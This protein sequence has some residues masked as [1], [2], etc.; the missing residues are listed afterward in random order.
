M[1][2]PRSMANPQTDF[3]L[4][5]IDDAVG[6]HKLWCANAKQTNRG[7][8]SVDQRALSDPEKKSRNLP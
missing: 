2:L 1:Y 4:Y 6:A 7:V 3:E 8:L 5:P